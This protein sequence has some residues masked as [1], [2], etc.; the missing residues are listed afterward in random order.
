MNASTLNDITFTL[1]KQGFS[2]FIA[3]R[4][5]YDPST[6]TAILDPTNSLKIKRG[7]TCTADVDIGAEDLA[8]NPLDH[9]NSTPAR[10][11]TGGSS[12]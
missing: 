9:N 5:S 1:R 4:V 12:R 3:A 8:G 6:D 2:G 7:A 10:S 11:R